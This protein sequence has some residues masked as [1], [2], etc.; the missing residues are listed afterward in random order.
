MTASGLITRVLGFFYRIYMV[1][2][3]G[4]EGMGLFQLIMPVYMLMWSITASGFTTTV[5][6]MTS[7]ENAM[8]NFGNIRTVMNKSL[9]MCITVSILSGIILFLLSGFLSQSVLKDARGELSLKTLA[10]AIPFMAAGS[11]LRG[12]FFGIQETKIP[13]LSQVLEQI[14][15]L[16]SLLLLAP[17]FT[18]RGLS[19]AALCAVIG[20]VLGEAISFF[21]VFYHYNKFSQSRFSN[22]PPTRPPEKISREIRKTALPLTMTRITASSLAAAENILI[23]QRLALF[24]GQA[25]PLAAYGRLTG[26][27][28]PLIQLPSSFLMALATSLMPAVSKAQAVKESKNIK[29]AVSAALLF[30]IITGMGAATLFAVFPKEI[31]VAVYNQRTLASLVAKLAF[32]APFMY[33]QIT[34][35][36]LLNGLGN[37]MFLFKL[38]LVSSVINVFF[39]YFLVPLFGVN[40]FI[41]GIL[42]SLVICSALSMKRLKKQAK[43]KTPLDKYVLKPLTCVAAAGLTTKYIQRLL[44]ASRISFFALIFLLM[45][46]YF[47]FLAALGVF[48]F[49]DIKYIFSKR[50]K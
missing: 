4:D 25:D 47:S 39:I 7:R 13:A 1:N 6:K 49:K 12:C 17:F 37:Q 8:H 41:C 48:S 40:G 21:Y 50:K 29:K 44:P 10:F 35:S 9:K 26:M 19:Q 34:L 18:G 32:I 23:P 43:V 24:S 14:I 31:S 33:L 28:M 45:A 20:I 36:G 38:S 30:T 15:R 27:A 11:C 3:I 46:L 22:I 42:A 16:G 2:T 5:S